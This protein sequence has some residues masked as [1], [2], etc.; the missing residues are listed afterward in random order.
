MRLMTIQGIS[1]KLGLQLAY[2]MMLSPLSQMN[3]VKD[4]Q[5]K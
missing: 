5:I 2:D 4:L 1:I 3:V